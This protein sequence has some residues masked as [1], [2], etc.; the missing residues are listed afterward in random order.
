MLIK[1]DEILRLYKARKLLVNRVLTQLL[2]HNMWYQREIT[3]K[4]EY[5]QRGE[6][7]AAKS[8]YLCEKMTPMYYRIYFGA[9][10]LNKMS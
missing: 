3:Y 8:R 7:K 5:A 4:L 1:K 9:W 6:S 2:W 10:K